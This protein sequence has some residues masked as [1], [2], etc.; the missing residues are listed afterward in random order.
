MAL[1]AHT[2]S[3]RRQPELTLTT[4]SRA[5]SQAAV[6]RGVRGE[7]EGMV[8]SLLMGATVIEATAALQRPDRD[9]RSSQGCAP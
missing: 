3:A 9:R 1:L 4:L 2:V 7:A 8:E 5:L 6:Q